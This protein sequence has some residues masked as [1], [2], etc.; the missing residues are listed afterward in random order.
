VLTYP[1]VNDGCCPRARFFLRLL[2]PLFSLAILIASAWSWHRSLRFSDYFY[3]LTPDG[4][5][6]VLK[7]GFASSGGALLFGWLREPLGMRALPP[8]TA[9]GYHHEIH[10]RLENG[11]SLLRVQPKRKVAALGFGVSSGEIS[12]NIPMAFLLPSSS[13]GVTYVP[14]YFLM[15]LAAISPAR[16]AWK[17]I[18]R[19]RQA[20]AASPAAAASSAAAE[21]ACPPEPFAA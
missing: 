16:L 3:R 11:V 8:P 5:S 21:P 18:R 4:Q 19:Y 14:Y 6:A 20:P 12:L 1:T 9:D 13:Y 2:P 17:W 10:L 15:L 7:R